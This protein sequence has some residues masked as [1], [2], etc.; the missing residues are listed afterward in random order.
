MRNGSLREGSK[1]HKHETHDRLSNPD[2]PSQNPTRSG[3]AKQQLA[4]L[5]A[6][7]L[8]AGAADRGNE[9]S[10]HKVSDGG[11]KLEK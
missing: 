5:N 4:H 7:T 1:R 3:V 2:Q 10:L 6:K 11:S 9:F 8:R